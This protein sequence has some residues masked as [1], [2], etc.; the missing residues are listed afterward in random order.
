MPTVAPRALALVP[1]VLLA[2]LVAIVLVFLVPVWLALPV[3]VFT[4]VGLTLYVVWRAPS[5]ALKSLDAVPLPEGREPRLESIV[6]SICTTSGTAEPT[7]HVVESRAPDVAVLGRLD[8]IHLV[9]TTGALRQL[10]RLELEAVVA[11]Q[12]ASSHRGIEASTTLVPA[13]T[14]LGPLAQRLR[15]RLLDD[16]RMAAADLDGVQITRYPP[17]L[18]SALE[19]SERTGGVPDHAATRHLWLIGP[20]GAAGSP[21]P[22]L[23]ERIDTLREL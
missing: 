15:E 20:A 3:A 12:L 16:R 23:V 14:L 21:H 11:R 7:L 6:E 10:D 5:I 4:G 1:S 17:A 9:V 19:K 8:D 2:A 22:P 13:S 18:A